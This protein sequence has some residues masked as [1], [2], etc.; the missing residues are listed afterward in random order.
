MELETKTTM[1]TNGYLFG[2]YGHG[3]GHNYG[4]EFCSLEKS[5]G[6]AKATLLMRTG[7]AEARLGA[8][9]TSGDA[10]ILGKVGETGCDILTKIGDSECSITKEV[11]D[12][13]S[14]L[15]DRMGTYAADNSKYQ[16]D[17]ALKNVMALNSFE[18]D[19]QNRVHETRQILTKE[20]GDKAS[21]TEDIINSNA[22]RVADQLALQFSDV[23]NQ[24]RNFEISTAKQFCTL[25]TEGLKNTSRILETLAAN[26]YDALKDEV[27]AIR[28]DRYADKYG[29][30]FALQSQELNYLKNMINS[31]EQTQKFGSK[32]VQFGAGNSAGTA[33]TANQG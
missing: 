22:L 9:V 23:K 2:G 30:N 24:M 29:Y 6:D 18:R 16:A 28:A 13:K 17:I 20:I 26:K 14:T 10:S 31:V 7:D 19:I 5:I 12:V 11:G 32:T 15:I 27:D 4:T 21:R 25:E 3:Y 33:Q 8:L 1:D